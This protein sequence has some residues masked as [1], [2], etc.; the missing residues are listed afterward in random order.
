MDLALFRSRRISSYRFLWGGT[1]PCT[2]LPSGHS[3]CTWGTH[4]NQQQ[5]RES[6]EHSSRNPI[7]LFY[8]LQKNSIHVCL[9]NCW[10]YSGLRSPSILINSSSSALRHGLWLVLVDHLLPKRASPVALCESRAVECLTKRVNRLFC[11][12]SF[13]AVDANVE[14]WCRQLNEP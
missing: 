8:S 11:L 13:T 9:E 12:A 6:H 3:T 14:L 4:S 2:F 7:F 1:W 5:A 10:V